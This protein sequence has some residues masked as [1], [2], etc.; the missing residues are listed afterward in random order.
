MYVLYTSHMYTYFAF[1]FIVGKKCY[2]AIECTRTSSFCMVS[3]ALSIISFILDIY[4]I[5]YY[6]FLGNCSV[7]AGT[8][9]QEGFRQRADGHSPVPKHTFSNRSFATVT[10]VKRQPIQS[11]NIGTKSP[12]K[13]PL[14]TS[15]DSMPCVRVRED[16]VY[17]TVEPHI[18]DNIATSES[19]TSN[20]RNDQVEHDKSIQPLL[21]SENDLSQADEILGFSEHDIE[22]ETSTDTNNTESFFQDASDLTTPHNNSSTASIYANIPGI[23]RTEVK[24]ISWN[25]HLPKYCPNKFTASSVLLAKDADPEDP[26][27]LMCV[28]KPIPSLWLLPACTCV[29]LFMCI[30]WPFKIN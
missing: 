15:E 4:L 2:I 14:P 13:P 27:M 10:P 22:C 30:T 23:Y 17:I 1:T 6:L 8:F 20:N 7:G 3:L 11:L 28:H 26:T 21:S 19:L 18:L 9:I 12:G 24:E 5:L 25:V 16:D 29:N